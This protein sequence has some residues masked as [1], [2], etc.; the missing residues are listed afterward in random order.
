MADAAEPD[1]FHITGNRVRGR[2]AQR[3]QTIAKPFG[4][5]V[6]DVVGH[7]TAEKTEGDAVRCRG[8]VV[9]SVAQILDSLAAG[10][11]NFSQGSGN[12]AELQCGVGDVAESLPW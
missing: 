5:R 12:V 8:V 10:S 1:A 3:Y 7:R 6:I 2:T 4:E 9:W 11:G